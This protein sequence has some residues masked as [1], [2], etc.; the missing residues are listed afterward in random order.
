VVRHSGDADPPTPVPRTFTTGRAPH[1]A[2]VAHHFYLGPHLGL[3]HRDCL[4]GPFERLADRNLAGPA[5]AGPSPGSARDRASHQAPS[6]SRRRGRTRRPRPG[7]ADAAAA[8]RIRSEI[9]K[10]SAR[11]DARFASNRNRF[12]KGGAPGLRAVSANRP[13]HLDSSPA[14]PAIKA[15]S[16]SGSRLSTLADADRRAPTI[17]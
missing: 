13:P 3:P 7:S 2:Q 12:S 1:G 4:R 9:S 17:A 16:T 8:T 11:T 10:T 6:R 15:L 14:R 5:V